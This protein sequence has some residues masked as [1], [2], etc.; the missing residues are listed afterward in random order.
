[1][2]NYGIRISKDG[3]DVKTCD[4]KDT[5]ITS[6][7]TNLKGVISGSGNKS[8]SDGGFETITIAHNLGYVPFVQA[9][10]NPPASD[11]FLNNYYPLPLW[12]DGI[13][14]HIYSNVYADNSNV[15]IE[16]EQWNDYAETRNYKYKYFIY[17]D[18]AKI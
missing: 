17:I 16:I 11:D 5:V 14:D 15:Y 18:K 8:V 12:V 6:K 7:Y 9:F 2:G 4:D 10:L 13:A 1:M 3:K